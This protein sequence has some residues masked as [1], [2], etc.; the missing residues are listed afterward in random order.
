MKVEKVR[1]Q[2]FKVF[3]NVIL[4]DVKAMT[5]F[6]GANGVGK[7]T[8]FDVFGFLRDCLKENIGAALTELE[9]LNA[10]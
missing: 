4:D 3:Q 1:L 10:V 2:N 7:T 5:V 6:V 9:A 8:L